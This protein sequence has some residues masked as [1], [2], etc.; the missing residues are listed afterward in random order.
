MQVLDL[1]R[2]FLHKLD[3]CE[4]EGNEGKGFESNQNYFIEIVFS[5]YPFNVDS[6]V[7]LTNFDFKGERFKM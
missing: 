7:K 5:D 3:S 4:I 1:V 2:Q 6:H